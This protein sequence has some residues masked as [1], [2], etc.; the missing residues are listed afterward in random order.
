[1]G[2]CLFASSITNHR[3]ENVHTYPIRLDKLGF[4]ALIPGLQEFCTIQL[5]EYV[6]CTS[7]GKSKVKSWYSKTFD[8]YLVPYSVLNLFTTCS[9]VRPADY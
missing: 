7:P 5:A 8:E 4:K 2:T 3:S 9:F 1:M 6:L